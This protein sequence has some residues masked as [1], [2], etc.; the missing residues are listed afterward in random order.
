MKKVKWPH[1]N[2]QSQASHHSG[3]W[4]ARSVNPKTPQHEGGA[5]LA[6]IKENLP[7]FVACLENYTMISCDEITIKQGGL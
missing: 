5:P 4:Y 2:I 6:P 1:Q 3:R 7:R